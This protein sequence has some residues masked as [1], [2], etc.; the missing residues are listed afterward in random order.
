MA[1]TLRWRNQYSLKEDGTD[2][3]GL[4]QKEEEEEEEEGEE[5]GGEEDDD[6]N[7]I[8][9]IMCQQ[10]VVKIYGTKFRKHLFSIFSR[11]Y[12]LIH[13]IRIGGWR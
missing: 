5:E 4:I 1:S 3:N 10:I 8:S 12:T 9:I 11:F 13:K 6:D 2:R 7:L